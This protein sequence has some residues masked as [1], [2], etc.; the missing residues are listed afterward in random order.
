MRSLSKPSVIRRLFQSAGTSG[1]FIRERCGNATRRYRH[2]ALV[3]FLICICCRISIAD[4]TEQPVNLLQLKNAKLEQ[5]TAI[6]SERAGLKAIQDA[7]T[8]RA[9]TATASA[10]A[11]LEIVYGFSNATVSPQQLIVHLPETAE[12]GAQTAWIEILVSTLAP[13][14]GFQRLRSEFLDSR[15]QLHSFSFPP[16]AAK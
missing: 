13:T 3:A 7:N 6:P 11:P 4:D 2:V 5:T 8:S 9:V 16:T 15:K 12:A 14:T 10:D 1:I